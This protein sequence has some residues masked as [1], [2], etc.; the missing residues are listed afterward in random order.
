MLARVVSD[1][2]RQLPG[3]QNCFSVEGRERSYQGQ[4]TPNA[5]LLLDV[6]VAVPAEL[7]LLKV[8]E[9]KGGQEVKPTLYY[10]ICSINQ[11]YFFSLCSIFLLVCHAHHAATLACEARLC[12]LFDVARVNQSLVSVNR[13]KCV[14]HVDLLTSSASLCATIIASRRNA[15]GHSL[16]QTSTPFRLFQAGRRVKLD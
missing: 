1:L 9:V 8:G 7:G 4:F 2:G 11:Y 3:A 14:R 13:C 10:L 6:W 12:N 5:S 15:A 16:L